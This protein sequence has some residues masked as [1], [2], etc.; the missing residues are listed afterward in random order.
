M[1]LL[2]YCINFSTN[3]QDTKKKISKLLAIEEEKRK[4]QQ[5]SLSS[6]KKDTGDSVGTTQGT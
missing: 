4:A 5:D 2:V 6:S 3:I 1:K